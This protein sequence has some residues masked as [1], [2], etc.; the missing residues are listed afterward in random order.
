MMEKA[1]KQTH[2]FHPASYYGDTNYVYA[3]FVNIQVAED[4]Y[5]AAHS[6]SRHSRGCP[7][8]QA[9]NFIMGKHCLKYKPIFC[10]IGLDGRTCAIVNLGKM[11]WA[12]VCFLIY[13]SKKALVSLCNCWVLTVCKF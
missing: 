11:G 3:E 2:C 4:R 12:K 7:F 10:V 6:P 8:R 9:I 5:L 13:R 1:F